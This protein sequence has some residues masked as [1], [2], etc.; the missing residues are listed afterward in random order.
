MTIHRQQ[1]FLA[2]NNK[3]EAEKAFFYN[4]IIPDATILIIGI[5]T[6]FGTLVT[7]FS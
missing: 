6:S 7:L 2:K 3:N 5:V 4:V 1:T